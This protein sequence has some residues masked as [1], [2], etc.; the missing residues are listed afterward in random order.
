M[1]SSDR[2]IVFINGVMGI[3][4]SSIFSYFAE[5]GEHVIYGTSRKGFYFDEYI[6]PIDGKLPQTNLVFSL[7]D[8]KS[9]HYQIDIEN[10]VD[11][12]PDLPVIFIHS[13]GEYAT[14]MSRDGKI[15]IENDNDGDGINDNVKCLSYDV[16]IAFCKKLC[17]AKSR[18]VFIQIGSLSDKYRID[19]H[20]SWVKSMDLLK[21]DLRALSEK[22]SNLDALILNVSSLLTPKELIDRPFVSLKTNA[23]MSYWLPPIEIAKFIDEYAQELHPGFREEELFK[24]WPNISPDHFSLESYKV[25]RGRELYD[26]LAFEYKDVLNL[27]D[28]D[29]I[30]Y[31]FGNPF[32]MDRLWG[33]LASLLARHHHEHPVVFYNPHSWFFIVRSRT[34]HDL[35]SMLHDQ[36]I[37][38]LVACGSNAPLNKATLE[39]AFANWRHQ[40]KICASPHYGN[41]CYLNVYDDFIIEALLDSETSDEIDRFYAR[42][43]EI[44]AVNI[45]ELRDIV[46]KKGKNQLTI[47]RDKEKAENLRQ[48]LS[49]EFSA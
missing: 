5:L 9:E 22:H 33:D 40:Y 45:K 21:D 11:A 28:G 6:D 47:S 16:P 1:G 17:E 39:K 10:L 4:G 20:G 46:S 29:S 25:R 19:I 43:D 8:Y 49:C 14:E 37:T 3:I 35:F 48:E 2:A 30:S 7:A 26:S 13:M 18:V 38:M 34:E 42:H 15:I 41:N 36:G 31:K 32:H 23:D 12:L 44:D 27:A 24:K